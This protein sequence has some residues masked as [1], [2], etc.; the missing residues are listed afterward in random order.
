MHIVEVD[1]EEWRDS[2]GV[3]VGVGISEWR[4]SR[5]RGVLTRTS[6]PCG[7][8]NAIECAVATH[9]KTASQKSIPAGAQHD[10]MGYDREWRT[11]VI[12]HEGPVMRH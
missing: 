6:A 3:R 1:G 5:S 8:M 7:Q 10:R 4:C 2:V 11:N 12:V 9:A